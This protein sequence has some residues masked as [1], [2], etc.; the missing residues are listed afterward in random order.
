MFL[1]KVNATDRKRN[2]AL[3]VRSKSVE[4]NERIFLII[5]FFI[6]LFAAQLT[7]W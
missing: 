2:L 3:F 7:I 1:Y 5:I 6:K 4:F